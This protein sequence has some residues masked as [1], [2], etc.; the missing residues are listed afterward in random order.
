[1]CIR[2]TLQI[3]RSV[4]VNVL[5]IRHLRLTSNFTTVT[6]ELTSGHRSV[7]FSMSESR[8]SRCVDRNLVACFCI[9]TILYYTSFSALTVIYKHST[10]GF[11]IGVNSGLTPIKKR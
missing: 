1:M 2:D 10:L 4:G 9:N 8:Y 7:S 11:E 5:R 6:L 3:C